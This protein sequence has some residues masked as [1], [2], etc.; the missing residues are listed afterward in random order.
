MKLLWFKP[1]ASR[2]VHRQWFQ[3][4]QCVWRTKYDCMR[5]F[6]WYQIRQK[7]VDFFPN[8]QNS[9]P[10]AN[11]QIIGM[12]CLA[13]TLIPLTITC[14]VSLVVRHSPHKPEVWGSNTSTGGGGVNFKK[15]YLPTACHLAEK[16]IKEN[17][18]ATWA[19]W[20]YL[21]G[22]C[23]GANGLLF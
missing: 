2:D 11:L 17:S 14:Q 7:T 9:L 15:N 13:A 16:S 4:Q 10:T 22:D 1:V 3:C 20:F 12:L 23:N 6:G 5:L 19:R 18:F 21:L 8:W